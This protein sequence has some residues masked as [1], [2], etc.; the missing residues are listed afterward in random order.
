MVAHPVLGHNTFWCQEHEEGQCDGTTKAYITTEQGGIV[1]ICPG[2]FSEGSAGL[3]RYK[4]RM[5]L[6]RVDRVGDRINGRME[7]F[8][9]ATLVHEFS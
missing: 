1:V 8:L 5:A 6:V 4:R 3:G 9:G 7:R 2:V